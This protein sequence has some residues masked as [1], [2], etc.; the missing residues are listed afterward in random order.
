MAVPAKMNYVSPNTT[1]VH[2]RRDVTGDDHGTEFNQEA[3]GWI[4]TQVMIQNARLVH[5]HMTLERNGFDMLEKACP[6]VDFLDSQQVLDIYYPSCEQILKE[7]YGTDKVH[8][9]AFDHNIRI[10]QP[11]NNELKGAGAAKTQ[12]PLGMVHGDYTMASGPRRLQDLGQ[13][14][15]ANDVWKNRLDQTPLLDPSMVEEALAGKRRFALINVWRNIDPEHPVQE[16]PLACV[17]ALSASKYD[18]RHL[19]I[20]YADRVGENYFVVPSE[21][22]DWYYYPQMTHTEAMLIKQW[23][24]HGDLAQGDRD[25]DVNHSTFCIHSAFVD[26][27]TSNSAADHHCIPRKSIEVRCALIWNDVESPSLI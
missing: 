24:S 26:P 22:H 19:Y 8:V 7:Y 20:H 2:V 3:D 16:L 21:S 14:P 27:T 1:E 17:D 6:P 11:T 10:N 25:R 4:P 5:Q 15:K 18:L 12:P 9:R 23:D 13:P